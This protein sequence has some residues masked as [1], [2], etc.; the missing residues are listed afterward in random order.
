MEFLNFHHLRYFWMVAKRGSVRKAA[1]ELHVS[2]P[3]ISAQL[4]LLEGAL[5]DQLF[6]RSGRNL[7]LTEKG[8]LVLSY[9]DDIFSTGRELMNAVRQQPGKRPLRLNI[10]LTDAFPKVMAFQILKA[11]FRFTDGIHVVCRDGEIG[12]LVNQLQAHRLDL[13]L[14]D[15]PASSTLKTKTF[16]HRL[17]YSGFTFCAVD[18]LAAKLRR[19]FPQSLDGAPALLPTANMGLRAALN[20]W[21]DENHIHPR[22][23]GEFEDSALMGVCAAGG[24]GFTIVH[25]VVERVALKHYG[26]KLIGRAEDCGNEFYAISADRKLK[27]PGVMAITKHAYA[28]IFDS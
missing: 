25:T 2:Q 7:V 24:R 6:R 27:H 26:L 28:A 13:V 12:P 16:N 4:K 21:F 8:H 15:E 5:G 22:V 20:T 1:E 9:A 3:S 14:S 19:N 17:G 23:V 18:S 10:G 11:A